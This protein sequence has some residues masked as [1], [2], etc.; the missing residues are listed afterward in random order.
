MS[1]FRKLCKDAL[2]SPLYHALGINPSGSPVPGTIY[3]LSFLL[4][5]VL[6]GDAVYATTSIPSALAIRPAVHCLSSANSAHG[7]A[8]RSERRTDFVFQ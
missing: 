1:C 3:P 8:C 7:N 4:S 5:G 6:R 2:S